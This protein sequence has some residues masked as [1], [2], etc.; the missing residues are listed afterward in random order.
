ME[1]KLALYASYRCL[2]AKDT[3]SKLLQE[4]QAQDP[5]WAS[6]VDFDVLSK[7]ASGCRIVAPG[8]QGKHVLA[9]SLQAAIEIAGAQQ[10][11]SV[12]ANMQFA[13]LQRSHIAQAL[14]GDVKV[15]DTVISDIDYDRATGFVR[16]NEVGEVLGHSDTDG[17][18]D[19]HVL[20]K[21]P[22]IERLNIKPSEFHKGANGNGS[23]QSLGAT[24][25]QSMLGSPRCVPRGV[26]GGSPRPQHGEGYRSARMDS[27]SMRRLVLGTRSNTNGFVSGSPMQLSAQ[28]AAFAMNRRG[29]ADSSPTRQQ[30]PSHAPMI[31][32]R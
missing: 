26:P 19:T 12:A 2:P 20:V 4:Q 9:K 24:T 15:G 1:E 30:F 6:L 10:A 32:S 8:L 29:V 17:T 21:F 23:F 3:S 13:S 18:R 5:K 14:L 27:A 11:P 16:K 25:A 31:R 22:H 28:S 7:I